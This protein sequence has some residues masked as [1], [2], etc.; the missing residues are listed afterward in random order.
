MVYTLAGSLAFCILVMG[1]N[2]LRLNRQLPEH[3]KMKDNSGDDTSSMKYLDPDSK[4]Q[5]QQDLQSMEMA[6]MKNVDDTA[7]SSA[8]A[9]AVSLRRENI[10]LKSKLKQYAATAADGQIIDDED[11][12]EALQAAVD[13]SAAR[14]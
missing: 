1:L 8:E 6:D 9:E 14:Y 2:V 7:V 13:P 3:M 10:I 11:V 5:H 12:N 4:Q